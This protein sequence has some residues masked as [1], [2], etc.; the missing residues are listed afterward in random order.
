VAVAST[1]QACD[2]GRGGT[3][4]ERVVG[5]TE[6]YVLTPD[7]RLVGRLDH[8]FKDAVRVKHAQIVQDELDKITIRIVKDRAYTKSDED[9]ILREARLRLGSSIGIQFDYADEIERTSNGKFHFIVS[10]LKQ[11]AVSCQE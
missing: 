1:E 5:R 2:C 6:D 8:L 11:E 3:I 7:G 4:I 9:E 10:N